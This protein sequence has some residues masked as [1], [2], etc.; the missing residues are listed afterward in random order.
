MRRLGRSVT[1]ITLWRFFEIAGLSICTLHVAR[2]P[3]FGRSS[4]IALG[5]RADTSNKS[6]TTSVSVSGK[7]GLRGRDKGAKTTREIQSTARRDKV[8]SQTPPIRGYSQRAGKSLFVGDC[9]VDDPVL[10]EP[11][12]SLNSLLAGKMQ[13]IFASFNRIGR[14]SCTVKP[15]MLLGIFAEFPKQSCR[16]LKCQI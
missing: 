8:P 10:S 12:S 7:Q 15:L 1:G 9:V 13:G 3:A 16:E 2:Y 11:V 4:A 5:S 14:T 6:P